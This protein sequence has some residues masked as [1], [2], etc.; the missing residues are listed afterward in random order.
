MSLGL[1][2]EIIYLDQFFHLQRIDIIGIEESYFERI[3]DHFDFFL[4]DLRRVAE[5][6][7]VHGIYRG[8]DSDMRFGYM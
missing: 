3:L 8:E 5:L 1:I 6:F 2:G 7:G 4:S